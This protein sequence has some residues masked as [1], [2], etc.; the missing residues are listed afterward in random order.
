MRLLYEK[1]ASMS[2]LSESAPGE[3]P[4]LM[5]RL[6]ESGD[7]RLLGFLIA[8]GVPIRRV[9][10]RLPRSGTT[11]MHRAAE[12]G[13]TDALAVLLGARGVQL[14]DS[15]GRT[16]LWFAAGAGSPACV[17]MLCEHGAST[18]GFEEALELVRRAR[19]RGNADV[20]HYLEREMKV[21]GS[22]TDDEGR[23]DFLYSEL[24]GGVRV[25]LDA[26]TVAL[27]LSVERV[28]LAELALL[29]HLTIHTRVTCIEHADVECRLRGLLIVEPDRLLPTK[30]SVSAL[31]GISMWAHDRGVPISAPA[32]VL[33]DIRAFQLLTY[34]PKDFLGSLMWLKERMEG[35]IRPESIIT[36]TTRQMAKALQRRYEI[37]IWLAEH[38]ARND[39]P[40]DDAPVEEEEDEGRHD[41]AEARP[42][43]L[44]DAALLAILDGDMPKLESAGMPRDAR[45]VID[46]LVQ[47]GAE[48][49]IRTI[50][51]MHPQS[52]ARVCEAVARFGQL[53]DLLR[54]F[55]DE[56]RKPAVFMNAL[57]GESDRGLRVRRRMGIR[58]PPG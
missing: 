34:K 1:G 55:P 8:C 42:S 26:V 12:L 17:R 28:D 22:W 58:P 48:I 21:A 36:F 45:R 32:T 37:A 56:A 35:G 31:C 6:V 30:A 51:G 4:E 52:I 10:D 18:D 29:K 46:A 41:K 13:R 15:N 33:V 14:P 40:D 25:P 38:S 23:E 5:R 19:E 53:T 24:S 54:E 9:G 47:R 2:V 27:P 20:M 50:I 7:V 43:R 49:V 3:E 16:P 44:S 11:A 39:E 57:L